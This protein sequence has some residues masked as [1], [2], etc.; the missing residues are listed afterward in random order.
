MV[1]TIAIYIFIEPPCG[2]L[3]K[4]NIGLPVSRYEKFDLYIIHVY[5]YCCDYITMNPFYFFFIFI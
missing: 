3:S 2:V 1:F 5:R 4:Y